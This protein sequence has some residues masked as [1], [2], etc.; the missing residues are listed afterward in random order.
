MK[1]LHF[2]CYA[3]ISGDMTLGALV[4][5]GVDSE[6]LRAELRKLSVPG[7]GLDFCRDE[8]CG[9]TGTRALVTIEGEHEHS[10]DDAHHHH[11]EHAHEHSH[12]DEH[13]HSH[14]D[15]YHHHSH[16]HR[17]WKDIRALI[18]GSAI[19]EGAKARA[20]DIFSRIATA[21]A[22]VHGM[23]VDEVAFH[24]VGAVDSIIDI[25]GAA[26]CLD[27]LRPDKITASPIELGGGTVTCAHGVLPVPAPATL[28]LCRGLPV[29]TGGFD[30]EMTTPTGAAI[31]A[32]CVDE[33]VTQASFVELKTAYGIGTRKLSKPNVL[34]VS[35]RQEGAAQAD[36]PWR[37]ETLTQI[38][39]A[40]DD[41]T[42]EVLGFLMERLFEAGALDVNFIPCTMKKSRPGVIIA[43]LCA[44]NALAALRQTLIKHSTTIGFRQ[45]RL[46]RLSL[47][48]K[49]TR[50][51]SAL[52]SV[53]AKTVFVDGTA[54]RTKIEFDDRARIAKERGISLEDAE[55][56]IA[57]KQ[58]M[59]RKTP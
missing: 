52:G 59:E 42:G 1:T 24:E 30:K 12:D 15:A 17:R 46:E 34:R 36:S 56:Q 3:G 29:T 26:I 5:L 40:V 19:S 7:W 22:G 2:D 4:E 8:R 20:L 25:V 35:W 16:E 23:E 49:E 32:S 45:T 27:V 33:F 41:M 10:H 43:V 44:D 58:I 54:A 21:E 37:T 38:E 48:R 28:A 55:K 9:I 57:E 50:I 47:P 14:D 51:E 11:S 31:L 18:S 53:R 13:T 39:A 6:Y